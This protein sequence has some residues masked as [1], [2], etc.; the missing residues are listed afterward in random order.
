MTLGTTSVPAGG[1]PRL[2]RFALNQRSIAQWSV[3]ELIESC[4]DAG[5]SSVGLWREPVAE[6]G[7]E[8]TIELLDR[9]GRRVSSLCRGGFLTSADGPTY[10]DAIEDNRRAIEEAA[11]LRAACLVLVVGGLPA[12]SRDLVAARSRVRDAV[13]ELAEYAA[14]RGVQL[15][16]EPLH[17]MFCADRAVLS[18]LGQALDLAEDHPAEAV[19]VVVDAY[20]VWWDPDLAAQ[21]ERAAGRIASFQVSDWIVPLA[22]DPLL[23]RGVMGDGHVDLTG[24]LEMVTAAGYDGDIEVE[25][26]NAELWAADG[27]EVLDT[28]LRRYLTEVL[29]PT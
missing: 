25:I 4:V 15:A 12:G 8:R 21:I 24:M 19:G 7:L 5:V 20:H 13:A 29:P 23:S 28:L 26:F 10:R 22:A 17:P 18:T 16:L 6:Y 1:D 9:H 11:T 14:E 3:E 2:A 27:R